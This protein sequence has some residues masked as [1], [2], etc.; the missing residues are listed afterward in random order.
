[1]VPGRKRSW[2]L[3]RL[4]II[5]FTNFVLP[6]HSGKATW[7]WKMPP[8][9]HEHDLQMAQ[10]A[11]LLL[12]KN[13][14]PKGIKAIFVPKNSGKNCCRSISPPGPG[15]QS[16]LRALAR[17]GMKIGRIEAGGSGS[18][19]ICRMLILE[20]FSFDFQFLGTPC[21]LGTWRL[22]LMFDFWMLWRVFGDVKSG[23]VSQ[24]FEI[25]FP[26]EYDF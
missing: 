16:A 6:K 15:A 4:S 11:C 26:K 23:S 10:M 24:H 1:M 2:R 25:I 9:Q 3:F 19:K 7:H 8:I 22:Q 21:P 20:L 17:S 5:C 12:Q 18:V 14:N 13:A